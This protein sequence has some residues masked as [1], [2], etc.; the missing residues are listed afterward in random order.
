MRDAFMKALSVEASLNSDT[1]LITGDLGFGVLNNFAEQF[2][3]QFFNAGVA[4]QNMAAIACGMALEGCNVFIYSIANFP[5]LRCF[6]QIRNDIC[7]HDANVTIVSIGGGF[8]YGQLGMS[9][10][11]TEDLSVMRSLPNMKIIVPGD[12]NEAEQLTTEIHNLKGPKYLRIDKSCADYP[13]TMKHALGRPNVLGDKGEVVIF[14]IGGIIKEAISASKTISEEL[15]CEVKVVG[16]NCLKPLVEDEI[17][18]QIL[19]ARAIIT[20]EENSL[21]NGFGSAIQGIMCD[22]EY[23]A[24]PFYRYGI[25]DVFPNVVGDQMYLRGQFGL[26]GNQIAS[27]F[28]NKFA[29]RNGR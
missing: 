4:E 14:A 6:E 24:V 21:I 23:G 10:F 20:V 9:H 26:R 13:K 17:L 11:A 8:S 28:L 3:N 5:T 7:Y 27:T 12:D 18:E 15:K 2:P 25:T 19:D 22:N 29:N 16:I 1:V